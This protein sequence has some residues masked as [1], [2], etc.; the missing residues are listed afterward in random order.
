MYVSIFELF[1]IGIGPSSSHTMG[2]MF[3]AKEFIDLLN[4]KYNNKL[5]KSINVELYGSLAYTGKGHK[6]YEAICL[7]LSGI[8]P[9]NI[10]LTIKNKILHSVN[11]NN[12]I[13]ILNNEIDFDISTNIIPVTKNK[14]TSHPNPIMFS[15]SFVDNT[16]Y[17]Q[18]FYSIGGGF[19]YTDSNINK[20]SNK[21]YI[22]DFNSFNKLKELCIS[23]NANI[24]DII[25]EN[26][27]LNNHKEEIDAKILNIWN[28][29]NEIIDNGI[30]STGK[31]DNILNVEK[32]AR[33][34]NNKI[35]QKDKYDPLEIMDKVSVYAIATCEENASGNKIVTAP[36][37]GAAGIIPAVIKY[38]T[39]LN[40]VNNESHINLLQH[41][42]L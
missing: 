7:G 14:F 8:K 13:M 41:Q 29:M 17:K 27:Y 6:T 11:S 37:N 30:K 16:T 39:K 12:K 36:T 26:E 21:E 9:N 31:I 18:V 2:P 20:Q 15:C 32:R 22:Y 28:N 35:K 1:K 34:L 10:N 42:V 5:I 38:Y 25:L 40:T 33:Y 3:A 4:L 24:Y 19:V 23:K